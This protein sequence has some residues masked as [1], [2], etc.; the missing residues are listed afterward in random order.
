[1]TFLVGYKRYTLYTYIA[2]YEKISTIVEDQTRT[3]YEYKM[4]ASVVEI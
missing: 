4:L 3:I 1:M 2:E